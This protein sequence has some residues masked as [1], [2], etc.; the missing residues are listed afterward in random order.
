MHRL[1][2]QAQLPWRWVELL[3][4]CQQ[5]NLGMHTAAG[6]QLGVR[7]S[8]GACVVQSPGQQGA[9]DEGGRHHSGLAAPA[10]RIRQLGGV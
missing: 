7:A 10:Q 4:G 6:F 8:Q 3:Q 5:T 9:R 2:L 1:D